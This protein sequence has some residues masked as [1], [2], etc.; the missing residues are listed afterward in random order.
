M[1]RCYESLI[2]QES[3]QDKNPALLRFH[4]ELSYFR[5]SWIQPRSTQ[6]DVAIVKDDER[7]LREEIVRLSSRRMAAG[8]QHHQAA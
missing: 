7:Y 1:I 4:L 2:D 8:I 6:R 3:N 5:P